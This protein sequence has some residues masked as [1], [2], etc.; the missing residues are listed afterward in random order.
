MND[1]YKY[2]YMYV[3]LHKILL[4]LNKVKIIDNYFKIF[5]NNSFLIN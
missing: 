2:K 1:I 5:L 3:Y 4:L